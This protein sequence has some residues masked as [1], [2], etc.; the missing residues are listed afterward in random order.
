MTMRMPW[1]TTLATVVVLLGLAG[2]AGAADPVAR[3]DGE[4]PD[5]RV[6]LQEL[7][8]GSDGTLMLRMA[9]V[10]DSDKSLNIACELRE[11]GSE[12]CG[13]IS[14]VHLLDGA[15]KKKYLVLR[16][17]GGTC[18]CSRGLKVVPAKSRINVWAKFPAPPAD[19]Q[20]VSVV[21]PTFIPM[22]DVPLR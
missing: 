20:K 12:S 10:N 4:T 22:D 5:T 18:V 21:V 13:S 8:R 19:V 2:P 7:K 1:R 9:L 16:D 6:E 3:A 14:G 15:G 17:A 11:S